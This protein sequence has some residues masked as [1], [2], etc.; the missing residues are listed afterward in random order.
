MPDV[1]YWQVVFLSCQGLDPESWALHP[2]VQS[3]LPKVGVA[4]HGSSAVQI[5]NKLDRFVARSRGPPG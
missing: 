4:R 5:A 3:Y 2:E 1:E